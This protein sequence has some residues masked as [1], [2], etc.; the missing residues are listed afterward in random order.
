MPSASSIKPDSRF[1]GLFIGRSG[2]GKSAAAY[3][4]PHPIKVFDLDG[5]IRGGLVPWVEREGIEYVN[6]PPKPDKGTVFE[7][8]NNEFQSLQIL[9]RTGQNHYR[10]L[11]LDSITWAALDLLIDAIPI[12]HAANQGFDKGRK[13]GP[14]DM[15]GPAD[16]GFQASG[17]LQI[18]AYLRSLPIENVIVTAHIVNRWGKRKDSAGKIID[19]YGASEIVG[20]QLSLTDKLSE[21]VPSAF[22]NVFRFEKEDT[23]SKIKFYF[24]AQG[25]LARS[26]YPELGYQRTDITGQDFY[27]L[28]MEKVKKP[29]AP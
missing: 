20:E 6:F 4:F 21:N 27:K 13:I 9:C 19:P 12:T 8:L 24:D 26:T 23:G 18:L 5:R 7:L 14:M 29:N 3:S 11:V 25:E 22:D 10:T 15:G 16:Y 17:T 1:F 2:S 28:L